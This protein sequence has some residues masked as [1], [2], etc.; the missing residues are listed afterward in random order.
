MPKDLLKITNQIPTPFLFIE[1]KVLRRNISHIHDYADKHGFAVRPHIK[2]HK[3]LEIANMQLDSGA[4][5]LAVAKVQE[6]EV[7]AKP[8]PV[9]FTIAYPAVGILR[10]QRIAKLSLK[11]P[12]RVA[13]DTEY[14]MEELAC[15][16]VK[17]DIVIGILVMF[18]AGLHRCGIADPNRVVKLSQFAQAHSGLRFDGIQ[19]YLGHLYGDAA[20]DPQSFEQINQLWEPVYEALCNFGLKPETISSGSTPSLE[21]THLVRHINEIRV[22]TAILND[23]FVLKFNHCT[24]KDC[25]ARVVATVISDVVQGQ[26]IIDAGSKA[27]SAKQLLHNENL[28]MGYIPEYPQARIFRLHEEHGWVDVSSCDHPPKIGERLSIIPVNIS[29]CINLYDYFYLITCDGRLQKKRVDARGC[30]V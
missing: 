21:N 5:G 22:G 17:H 23:Y 3:S 16:A 10:A 19:M 24:T 4:V 26:V 6:A 2:T 9:D 30:L 14:A 12:V 15:E 8:G 27:L 1:E 13:V 20:I 11:N 25:A 7:M 28:E 18:D 29:L